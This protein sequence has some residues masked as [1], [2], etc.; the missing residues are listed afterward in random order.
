VSIKF[1]TPPKSKAITEHEH[2]HKNKNK[3]FGGVRF[4]IK[5]QKKTTKKQR[6]TK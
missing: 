6:K 3:I 5:Q 1:T 2:D 4:K